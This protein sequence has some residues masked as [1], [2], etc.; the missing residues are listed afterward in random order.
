MVCFR[1]SQDRRDLCSVLIA[2][3]TRV[4]LT[5]TGAREPRRKSR[6]Q[7]TEWCK[8]TGVQS[9]YSTKAIHTRLGVYTQ[10][11]TRDFI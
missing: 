6:S 8:R 5:N 9:V 1:Y 3:H 7:I 2:E 4:I 11:R 10:S